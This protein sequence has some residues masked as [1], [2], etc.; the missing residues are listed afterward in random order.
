MKNKDSFV[1]NLRLDFHM[2]QRTL[3]PV[4]FSDGLT[5]RCENQAAKTK[6]RKPSCENQAAKTKLRKPSCE[7]QAI[8]GK[9]RRT[10][11]RDRRV[12]SIRRKVDSL[13]HWR[14]LMKSFTGETT[15]PQGRR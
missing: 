12:S 13:A 9:T 8:I 14:T 2:T 7:N 6:L 1:H 4:R 11:R 3:A 10:V 5:G 15:I